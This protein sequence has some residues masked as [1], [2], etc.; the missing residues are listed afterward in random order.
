MACC[1]HWI[2][3]INGVYFQWYTFVLAGLD[4]KLLLLNRAISLTS[5]IQTLHSS[6][7]WT[8]SPGLK[9]C[10]LKT[11]FWLIISPCVEFKALGG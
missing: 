4:C 11:A 5:L 8:S 10:I 6:V 2:F 7:G 1:S 3:W 9:G